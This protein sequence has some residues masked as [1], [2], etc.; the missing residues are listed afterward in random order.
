MQK[1]TIAVKGWI[2]KAL[3]LRHNIFNESQASAFQN[4]LSEDALE[5]TEAIISQIS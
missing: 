5:E 4:V 3:T 2:L 1:S